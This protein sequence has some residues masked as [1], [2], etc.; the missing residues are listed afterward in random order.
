MAKISGL[1]RDY[2]LTARQAAM[3]VEVS[4]GHLYNL[5][6]RHGGPQHI[7]YRRQLRFKSKDL[8][9]WVN[10]RSRAIQASDPWQA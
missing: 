6:C 4:P 3:Y 8:D 2:P 10:R 7:K 1:L 9:V 5:I